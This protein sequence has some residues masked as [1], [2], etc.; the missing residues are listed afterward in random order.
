V[1]WGALRGAEAFVLPSHQENFGI[2]VVEA[3]ACGVPVIVSDKVNIWP[4]IAQDKAGIVKADTAEGTYEGMTA[5]L[6]MGPAERS[7]MVRNG[8]DCFRARY[9]MKRSARALNELF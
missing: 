4:E 9:E 7:M 5:L 1:K 6:A 3:L 8:V 2:A